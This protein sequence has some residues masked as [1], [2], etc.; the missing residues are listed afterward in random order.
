MQHLVDSDSL[1]TLTRE[2]LHDYCIPTDDLREI[3]IWAM[4]VYFRS[5]Q[6]MAPSLEAMQSE[7]GDVLS[8]HEVEID[9]APPDS[10]EWVIDDLKGSYT[11]RMG[12]DFTKR[13]AVAMAEANTKDRVQVLQEHA[14]Q[15]VQL[16]MDME[17]HESR[18]DVREGMAEA[19]RDYERR[20]EDAESHQVVGMRF[21]LSDID[22]YTRGIHP[23]ELA[24]LA[25]P[26]KVGK[27]MLAARTA[28]HSWRAGR[29]VVL[30]TLENSVQMTIDRMVCLDQG[31]NYRD[32]QQGR[33]TPEEVERVRERS[34]SIATSDTPLMIIRPDLGKRSMEMMVQQAHAH[35]ADDL[36][37]DQ[38]TF[39]EPPDDRAAR[40]TQIRDMMHALKGAISTGRKMLPALLV[41]QISREGTKAS[42]K[43]GYLELHHFAEGSEVERTAD[44][45]FGLHRSKDDLYAQTAKFQTLVSRREAIK[46]F[47][48][49]WQIDHGNINVRGEWNPEAVI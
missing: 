41:H 14:G 28:L 45:G 37:I 3:Y 25:A 10:I 19:L 6:V 16:A 33:C 40:H 46:H 4:E 42:D 35:G 12:Q 23:G 18:L 5:G 22:T 47:K 13:F 34:E 36:I 31:V 30:F 48:L 17:S 7:W 21:G 44:W 15:L 26:P 11:Y 2:G 8:D 43:T 49:T 27:S 39:V 32:W 24:V 29:C 20:A 38:L 9:V 1:A